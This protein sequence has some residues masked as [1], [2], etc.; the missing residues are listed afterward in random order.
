MSLVPYGLE[1]YKAL[2][3]WAVGILEGLLC[4]LS[5]FEGRPMLSRGSIEAGLS[6]LH[7]ADGR[8]VIVGTLVMA[9]E[10]F[11]RCSG[12]RMGTLWTGFVLQK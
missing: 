10:R 11:W 7:A 6:L 5:P 1:A 3:Q 8:R 9:I 12:L 2:S 4:L